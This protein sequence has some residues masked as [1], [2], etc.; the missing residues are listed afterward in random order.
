MTG[1]HLKLVLKRGIEPADPGEVGRQLVARQQ[2]LRRSRKLAASTTWVGDHASLRSV[3][4]GHRPEVLLEL[5]VGLAG[6]LLRLQRHPSRQ[7]RIRTAELERQLYI[8]G[9]RAVLIR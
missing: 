8:F 2:L 6:I 1:G 9:S 4:N 5:A 7:K 3:A